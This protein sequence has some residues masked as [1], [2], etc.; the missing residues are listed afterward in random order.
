MTPVVVTTRSG[1]VATIT[2]NRPE[3][4]NALNMAVKSELAAA[5]KDVAN[6]HAVRAVVLTGSGD[7]FC[8]GG[9]IREM[10]LNDTPVTS[11]ARLQKLLAEVTIPLAEMEKPTIAAVNGG[12]HGAGF[13]LALACD[14]IIATEEAAFSCAF[15]KMGLLPDCGSLYFLPRRTSMGVSKELV[16]TG[17]RIS[18]AEAVGYGIVNRTVAAAD[19]Q[20]EVDKL[21]QSLA[22]SA[23]VALALS[24]QLLDQSLQSSLHELAILESY[25]QAALYTTADNQAARTAFAEKKKP[26][27]IGS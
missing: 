5:I 8:A 15:S 19:F 9:D 18:A 25:G 17:R 7:A 16:F 4:K 1:G 21:A 14:I 26:E 13:S 2:L 11:R 22:A 10:D 23:T 12:A 24:K 6:D 20:A 3:A 27:F